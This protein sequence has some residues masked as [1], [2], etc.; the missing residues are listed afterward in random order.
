M[1]KRMSSLLNCKFLWIM[2]IILGLI[3]KLTLF[4][5]KTG[6][7]IGYLEP[8]M[9]FIKTHGNEQSLK[10]GFYD[11]TPSYIYILIAI[12]K[13]GLNPLFSVK[14]VSVF[15]EYVLAFLIGK[16]ATLKYKSNIV[17]WISLAIIPILPSILLNSS[18]LSQS[19]AIYSA[20][21][22]GSVYFLL[23][24]KQLLTVLFLGFAFAFKMQSAIILPFY[25]VMMLR[26]NIKWYYFSIVPIIYLLSILPT[27][28]Y[29]RPMNEL[30]TIYLSQSGSYKYLTLN[31]PNLYIW[32]SNV[33]YEPAKIVGIIST[34]L[35]TLASGFWLSNKNFNFTIEIWVKLAFLSAIIVPFVL[36]G[37]HERYMYLGDV[38]GVLYFLFNR[39]NIH[40]PIGILLVSLYSY[41]RCS[42]YNEILP[43]WPAFFIYL[44]VI[45]LTAIDFVSTLKKSSN[46]IAK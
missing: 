32:I 26:G 22:V 9:N 20:F 23:I 6:D 45:I 44:A 13:L 39:K 33:Y 28:F 17:I 4:S 15:F 34:A 11:Y 19:D 43:L 5:T 21:V 36:P 30:L 31:F 14:L 10:F 37:M 29:G 46:E 42:R 25:F 35:L 38:L 16:I 27:W 24:R 2:L 8:W 12:V 3:T 18:Y 7:Y 1:I 41:I 40:L